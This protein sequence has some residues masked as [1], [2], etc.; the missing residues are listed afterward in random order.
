[1]CKRKNNY[2]LKWHQRQQA[3]LQKK[4]G[5][6]EKKKIDKKKGRREASL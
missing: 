5:K 6:G 4:K 2:Q 1:M 3:L